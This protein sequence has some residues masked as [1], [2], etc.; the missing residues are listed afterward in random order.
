MI[1]T[2]QKLKARLKSNREVYLEID[3]SDSNKHYR[4][5]A[6]D[7]EH[8][9]REARSPGWSF[10]TPADAIQHAQDYMDVEGE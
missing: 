6:W 4:W 7:V 3:Y 10:D 2:I 5:T 8:K 9:T 1:K